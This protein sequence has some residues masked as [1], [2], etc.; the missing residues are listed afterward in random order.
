MGQEVFRAKGAKPNKVGNVDLPHLTALAFLPH[1]AQ[2]PAAA[3]A[4]P[5]A[6]A[7]GSPSQ[8]VLA[9]TV[10]VREAVRCGGAGATSGAL[11]R[12]AYCVLSCRFGTA[13]SGAASVPCATACVCRVLD[14]VLVCCACCACRAQH[15]LWLYDLRAG[16]RPQLD[17]A[18][19]DARITGL[20][21]EPGGARVWVANGAGQVEALELRAQRMQVRGLWACVWGGSVRFAWPREGSACC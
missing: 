15:K 7:A 20:A 2:G 6:A 1:M 5:A 4:A 17:L 3:G 21:A 12:T 19:G 16:K 18:W 11:R 10:K 13:F 14:R 9:G 8:L